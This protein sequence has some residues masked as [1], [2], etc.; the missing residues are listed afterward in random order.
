MIT[1]FSCIIVLIS[2]FLVVLVLNEWEPKERWVVIAS[3]AIAVI[4][5]A[6]IIFDKYWKTLF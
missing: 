3:V 2:I 5:V 4:A 1:I 6:I